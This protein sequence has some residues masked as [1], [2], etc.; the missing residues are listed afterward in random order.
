MIKVTRTPTVL[1]ILGD[2]SMTNDR[3]GH[4]PESQAVTGGFSPT[5]DFV[6]SAIAGLL[7]GFGLDWLFDTRPLFIII[8]VT[9][10]FVSGFYKLWKSSEVLEEMAEERRRGI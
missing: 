3:T 9:A 4:T 1:P 2:T 7:L 5:V 10:G 8:F 6:S